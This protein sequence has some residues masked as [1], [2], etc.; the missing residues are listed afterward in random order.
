MNDTCCICL[1]YD[2]NNYTTVNYSC[3]HWNCL[4]CYSQLIPNIC[5][6]CRQSITT[7]QYQGP[8]Q[9]YVKN[10]YNLCAIINVNLKTTIVDDIRFIMIDKW[11]LKQN[12]KFYI[13]GKLIRRDVLLNQQG[14]KKY[15]TLHLFYSSY[16][17][18]PT[19]LQ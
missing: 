5:P 17:T 9:I 16:G 13:H 19:K 14:V 10:I 1:D 15:D 6:I 4:S 8:D 2:K 11:K 12:I 18:I 7:V 3:L